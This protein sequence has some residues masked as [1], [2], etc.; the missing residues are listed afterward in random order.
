[1]VAPVAEPIELNSQF[2]SF[3]RETLG[4][5]RLEMTLLGGALRGD[6]MTRWFALNVP[7]SVFTRNLHTTIASEIIAMVQE[8][9]LPDVNAIRSRIGAKGLLSEAMKDVLDVIEM[10]FSSAMVKTHA[11]MVIGFATLRSL[12]SRA[13]AV[14]D[15]CDQAADLDQILEKAFA[16][17]RNLPKIGTD[18]IMS[19]EFDFG[20]LGQ[21]APGVPT[22]W[23]TL[24]DACRGAGWYFGEYAVVMGHRGTGKTGVM[25]DAAFAAHNAGVRPAYAT[26]EMTADEVVKRQLRSLCG[27]DEPPRETVKYALFQEAQEAVKAMNMPIYDPRQMVG[28]DRSVEKLVSW[29]YDVR[30]THGVQIVFIDYA[31]KLTTKRKGESRTREMDHCAD[32]IDDLVKTTGMAAVVGSQRSVDQNAKG[33][34][35]SKDSIKWEDNAAL[36]L[37]LRRQKESNEAKLNVSKNRNGREPNFA[38]LYLPDQV[39]YVEPDYDPFA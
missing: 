35:R 29:A 15:L 28:G 7:A 27:E 3:E 19:A 17:P 20:S 11:G 24:N 30:V 13:K 38:A 26:L 4:D 16:M 6:S 23:K 1:M 8:N 39:K 5:Y 9:Q 22:P 32:M 31:Q 10:E 36:V 25:V 33:V 18:T 2:A 14:F 37:E 12:R 34:W 21:K